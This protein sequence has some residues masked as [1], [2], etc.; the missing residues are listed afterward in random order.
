MGQ[1]ALSRI[2]DALALARETGEH[3]SDSF[4]HRIRG[5]ILL[6]QNPTNAAV[7]E[8]AFR[9][10]IV[11]ARTQKARS[12]ELQAAL[13]LAKLYHSTARPVDARQVLASALQGFSP[14]P[15]MPEI[16]EAQALL[17]RLARNGDGTSLA[18]DPATEG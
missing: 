17:E 1:G 12:F 5:E 11:T 15:E 3:W 2:D 10:A 14:T 18:Q 9:A 16:A 8:E 6:K 13:G 4:L 7:A